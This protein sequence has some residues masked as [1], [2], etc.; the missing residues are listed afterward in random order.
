[1]NQILRYTCPKCG[2]KQY[3]IGEMWTFGSFWTKMF[4]LHAQRFTFITCHNCKYTEIY[5]VQK[6]NIGE[7]INF[8]AR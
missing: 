4:Q 1:M 2:N 8:L 5:N 3:K 7:D 6:K